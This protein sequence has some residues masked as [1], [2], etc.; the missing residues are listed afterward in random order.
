MLRAKTHDSRRW[1]LIHFNA[2]KL[3]T[4]CFPFM[5]GWQQQPLTAINA[6]TPF[7]SP[8]IDCSMNVEIFINNLNFI[9]LILLLFTY[10]L[11]CLYHI[12]DSRSLKL[13]FLEFEQHEN[14]SFIMRVESQRG[15]K[16]FWPDW[17]RKTIKQFLWSTLRWIKMTMIAF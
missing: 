9:N 5:I 14:V 3:F 6:I 13:S 7:I 11:A 17:E 10:F 4:L 1:N 12:A 16:S 2:R 8:Y 15:N